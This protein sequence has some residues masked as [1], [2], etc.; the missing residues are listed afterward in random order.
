MVVVVR[1]REVTCGMDSVLE[2]DDGI[3]ASLEFEGALVVIEPADEQVDED[4][5]EAGWEL[6]AGE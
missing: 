6:V 2:V 5:F 4:G 3:D 1:E